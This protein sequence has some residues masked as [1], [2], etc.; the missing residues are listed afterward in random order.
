M[1]TKFR[2]QTALAALSVLALCAVSRIGAAQAITLPSVPTP[3]PCTFYVNSKT[4]SNNNNGRTAP[5]RTLSYAEL[6]VE[7]TFANYTPPSAGIAVC[8]APGDYYADDYNAAAALSPSNAQ[9]GDVLDITPAGSGT[10]SIP[11]WY[12]MDPAYAGQTYP[13]IH[14]SGTFGIRFEPGARY[15]TIFELNV[16]GQAQNPNV[17][18]ASPHLPGRDGSSQFWPFY[19]GSCIGAQGG[20]GGNPVEQNPTQAQ[21]QQYT[22]NHISIFYSGF[23]QCGGGGIAFILSDYLTIMYNHVAQNSNWSIYQAS[24]ISLLTSVDYDYPASGSLPNGGYKNFVVG[25]LVAD[26]VEM[27]APSDI[28]DGEGIIIDTNLNN[29]APAGTGP[30]LNWNVTPKNPLPYGVQAVVTPPAYQGSTLVANNVAVG[31]GGDGIEVVKSSN[32][33]VLSNSTYHNAQSY[34]I[35]G[36]SYEGYPS[37]RGEF[38]SQLSKNVNVFNNSFYGSSNVSPTSADSQGDAYS[39]GDQSV[40]QYANL[41]YQ[42]GNTGTPLLF[43]SF[44]EP[45]DQSTAGDITTNPYYRDANNGSFWE[46]DLTPLGSGA[47]ANGG[48]LNGGVICFAPATDYNGNP[49]TLNANGHYPYGAYATTY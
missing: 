38:F 31:N 18:S 14:Q 27:V 10:P 49:R 12:M 35:Y 47:A 25:N 39:S 48:C 4:G 23:Y 29:A 6:N 13:T 8:I 42:D 44:F 45:S 2:T 5:Y 1:P 19:D 33:D 3:P 37:N 26:N 34:Q 9:S 24:G 7:N 36:Y 32:V 41:L 15:V 22:P 17:G 30:I 16:Y 28:T 11:V 43:P 46:L 20:W 40:W 21:I